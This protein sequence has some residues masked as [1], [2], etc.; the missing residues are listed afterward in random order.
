MRRTIGA[1][2]SSLA[3]AA[4]LSACGGDP[5]PRFEEQPSAAP[6]TASPSAPAEPEPWEEKSDDGAVA[7]V[8]HWLTLFR[9]AENSGATDALRS[10]SAP[11]CESCE[12]F[13]T[14]IERIYDQGGHIRSDG[15]SITTIAPPVRDRSSASVAFEVRQSDQRVRET[16]NGDEVVNRGISIG[17]AA[18]LTWEDGRWLMGRLDIVR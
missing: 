15:W 12:R 4:T 2:A 1:L 8:G 3:L 14:E 11:S 9:E 13:A 7:F 10:A 18:E 16:A 6:S 5:E 17:L